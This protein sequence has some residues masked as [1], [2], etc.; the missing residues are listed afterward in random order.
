MKRLL[1]LFLC[2]FALCA[3][4]EKPQGKPGSQSL[5]LSEAVLEQ[6]GKT[7]RDY[8]LEFKLLHSH[9]Y[10]ALLSEKNMI[11]VAAGDSCTNSLAQDGSLHRLEGRLDVMLSGMEDT[12]ALQ[13]FTAALPHESKEAFS[14]V[15]IGAGSA[16]YV[17][18]DGVP[19]AIVRFDSDGDGAY[20]IHMDIVLTEDKQV[21][22]SAHTW[23]YFEEEIN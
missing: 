1:A 4:E 2:L 5:T 8:D 21:K 13:D 18:E 20:D 6:K 9:Y 3:C 14:A 7:A 16:Y 12:M 17:A 23:L 10:S 19:Y 15:D 11:I 22:P